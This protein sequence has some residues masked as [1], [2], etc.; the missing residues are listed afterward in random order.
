MFAAKSKASWQAFRI[1]RRVASSRDKERL[2]APEDR[3]AANPIAAPLD[4]A[5][6][7]EVDLPPDD[8][9]ELGFHR[10]VVE[11]APVG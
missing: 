7:H 9:R 6:M 8:L 4:R 2:R 10:H 5:T 11:Q 1:S 3:L